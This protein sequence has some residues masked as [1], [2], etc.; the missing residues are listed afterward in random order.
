VRHFRADLHIHSCLSPCGDLDMS[1]R[2]IVTRSLEKGLDLIAVCDHNSAENVGA[3]IRAGSPR[4]LAVLPGME[5]SSRE[6]VHTL[7][8]FDTEA[9]A[10]QMQ[11]LIYRHLRGTNR[12]ELFGDQVVANELDEVEGF[13][14]R[15]LIGAVQMDLQEIVSAVHGLG[16]LSI[17]SHVDRPS[18]SIL[19]QL[20]FI[21][22]EVELDGLEISGRTTREKARAEIPG[23]ERFTL[24]SFSDAHF[25]QDIGSSL[26]CFLLETPSVE[27]IR[28]ALKEERGRKVVG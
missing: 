21:P 9:R 20:G 23:L 27:E 8:L 28:L 19:S 5:I 4:G 13:N 2:T 22:G 3:V 18:F 10:L 11:E 16:G 7:A 1:P 26:T 24:M 12:P 17:A 15:L 25:P 14:D 6:E